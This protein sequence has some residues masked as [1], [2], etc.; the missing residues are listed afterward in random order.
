MREILFSKYSRERAPEYAIR[1][2]IVRDGEEKWAEKVPLTAE[3]KAH[4]QKLAVSYAELSRVYRGTRLRPCPVTIEGDTAKFAF[5]DCPSF[6]D[7]LEKLVEKDDKRGILA[8][9]QEFVSL[10]TDCPDVAPFQKTPAFT[11]VFGDVELPEGLTSRSYS[12]IDLIFENLMEAEDGSV[13]VLDYEWCYDF[14]VPLEFI[15]YRSLYNSFLDWPMGDFVDG[16]LCPLL[17]ISSELVPVFR[18]MEIAFNRS[19]GTGGF[20]PFWRCCR[21]N[22]G[23]SYD[24]QQSLALAQQVQCHTQVFFDVGS[25][26]DEAQSIH[27]YHPYNEDFALCVPVRAGCTACR[28]DPADGYAIVTMKKCCAVTPKGVF[29]L[30]VQS[31]GL[32]A[33]AMFVYDTPDCQLLFLNLQDDILEIRMILNVVRT[34]PDTAENIAR[35]RYMEIQMREHLE[36]KEKR[37]Q[38]LENN[39]KKELEHYKTHYHAAIAQRENLRRQLEQTQLAYDDISNAFFWKITKPLRKLSEGVKWLL[40]SN[41]V[42]YLFCKGLICLKRHGFKYTWRRVRNKL[43]HRQDY[44]RINRPLFTEEELEQQRLT[45]FPRDAKF[46]ILVPLYNTPENFLR[47]MIQSVLDQTYGNWEL[48]L[49]DGS[50][51]EHGSVEKIARQYAAKDERI[52]YRKLEKNLGISGNTNACIDMA[53]GDYIALFD[54]DDLLHPAALYC[55]METITEQDADFLYTDETTF[56]N[57]PADAYLPHFKPDFAP[58]TLRANNY[59]CHFTAFSRELQE[60]VG[61]FRPECDGSQD[62]DMV[63]RLTEKAKRIVHIP[64]I[65]YY[66]RASAASVAS[67]VGAKPYVIEAA[68]KAISD[69]LERVGLKGEVLDSVVP[70]MYRLKYEIAEESLVSII[71]CTKD[72]IDDLKKCLNSIWEKTTYPNYEIIIVENNSTEPETFA[73]YETLKDRPNL[74]VVTWESPNHEFNYSAINNYGAQFARGKYVLLLNNDVEI[75]SPDWIQEMVMYVQRPDVGAAGAKLYYPDDT[76]QHAGVGIGLLTLAG[77]YHRGFPRSHPGYMGRLIYAQDLSAVTAACMMIR[78]DVWDEVGGLDETFKVAFNDVDLCMRIRAAGYLIVWTP[79]AEL[80]HY[81]SKSR[82]LED[83]PQKRLRFEGEVERFQKRWAKELAAGDPYYNPNF[84]LDREDF[85]VR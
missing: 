11:A 27:S 31:N 19:I 40:R 33:G 54:H 84:T 77:H 61:K 71:I 53:T 46:S 2:S 25:G 8:L 14:P 55:M 1:T 17:G 4:I 38:E 36:A 32:Q 41:R 39:L 73:Y 34:T 50:D 6:H 72:H 51:A 45:Q 28:V 18:K 78:R 20:N 9:C 66:W 60:Q 5:I 24:L 83:T 44:T 15:L 42:T 74:Q 35:Q 48:C 52:R 81:E 26:F 65:L 62:F 64:K 58:D 57:V 67:D 29:D 85:S 43:R 16:T 22:W 21:Q 79:F 82:G 59:I 70:S 13:I 76:I 3:A 47:E 30:P 12:N 56:H 75:I 49:A 69:H 63:L 23:S 68:H 80:Y 10:V 7:R 37:Q